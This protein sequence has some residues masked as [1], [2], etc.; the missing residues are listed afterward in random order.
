MAECHF[1]SSREPPTGCT[2]TKGWY[3]NNGSNTVTAVD[4]RTKA[5]AQ[6]IFNATPGKPGGVTFGNDNNNLNL[7]QQLLAAILNGGLNGPQSVKDAIADAL[8]ATDGTGLVITVAA[9]TDVGGLI[10]SLSNF[11]EGNVAGFPHCAD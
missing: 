1:E 9:G 6:A 4:G 10:S 8:A 11:N 7:Y 3:R 2:F 5:E